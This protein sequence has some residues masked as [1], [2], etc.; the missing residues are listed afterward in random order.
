MHPTARLFVFERT[1]FTE[2]FITFDAEPTVRG[3]ERPDDVAV[4]KLPHHLAFA[5][6]PVAYIESRWVGIGD[7]GVNGA[8][9]RL[10]AWLRPYFSLP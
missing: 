1:R 2:R 7:G 5:A 8:A 6:G 9:T 3:F 10:L 4:M